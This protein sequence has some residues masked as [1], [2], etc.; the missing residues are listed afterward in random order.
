MSLSNETKTNK[1]K[2]I[3][4]KFIFKEYLFHFITLLEL[5]KKT[6]FSYYPEII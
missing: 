1:S 2:I 6:T 3:V 5:E 4:S